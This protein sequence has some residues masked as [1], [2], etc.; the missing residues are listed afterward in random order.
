MRAQQKNKNKRAVS[1]I[2]SYTLLIIIAVGLSVMVYSYLKVY[3]PKEKVECSED[4]FATIKES[5]CHFAN[6][7]ALLNV[8][9]QNKGL[10]NI[11]SIYLRVGL[12]SRT[13]SYLIGN[14]PIPLTSPLAPGSEINLANIPMPGDLVNELNN[15]S[16]SVQPATKMENKKIVLCSNA[17]ISQP[18]ECN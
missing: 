1:E 5:S 8:T 6:G 15:Y 2:V 9:I 7:V 11:S 3:T 18:I 14:N 17:I 10:F 13:T 16:L 4:I 12:P